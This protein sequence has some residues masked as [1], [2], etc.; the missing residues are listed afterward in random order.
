MKK[1]D[2]AYYYVPITSMDELTVGQKVY[3]ESWVN[4]KKYNEHVVR[5]RITVDHTNG[6][7]GEETVEEYMDYKQWFLLSMIRKGMII[8]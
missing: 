4:P 6:I 2:S 8:S 1:E 7:H 3:I 5:G